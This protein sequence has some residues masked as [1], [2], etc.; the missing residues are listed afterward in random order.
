MRTRSPRNSR[1]SDALHRGRS[2]TRQHVRG[3]RRRRRDRAARPASP[4]R[5]GERR[6]PRRRRA[7]RPPPASD[8][9]RARPARR[10]PR[11]RARQDRL[12]RPDA[13][14][15]P[16]ARPPAA[17]TRTARGRRPACRSGSRSPRRTG[18]DDPPVR[19]SRRSSAWPRAT[20]T[21]RSTPRTPALARAHDA[22]TPCARRTMTTGGATLGGG[23]GRRGRAGPGAARRPR[24]QSRVRAARG[25]A[26][27]P[28]AN[29]TAATPRQATRTSH[30]HSRFR[31]ADG[32]YALT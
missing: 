29:A 3:A 9:T 15:P 10:E 28:S 8:S 21:T 26:P 4:R 20:R 14:R 18:L 16:A 2:Q 13:P 11:A 12:A 24:R 23:V 5:S 31:I 6:R 27:R 22:G 17:S 32:G 1:S 30:E 19:P 25:S 7:R